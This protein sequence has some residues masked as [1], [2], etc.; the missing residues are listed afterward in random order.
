MDLCVEGRIYRICFWIICEIIV[1]LLFSKN[2]GHLHTK[3]SP[4]ANIDVIISCGTP[5]ISFSEVVAC[6]GMWACAAE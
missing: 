6:L 2:Y 5:T 3:C 1:H 4:F